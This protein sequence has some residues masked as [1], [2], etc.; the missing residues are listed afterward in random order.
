MLKAEVYGVELYPVGKIH[1][2]SYDQELHRDDLVL[3]MTDFG[4]DVGRVLLGPREMTLE[5]I[6][7]EV[8]PI[9]KKIEG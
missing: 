5:Q 2:F 6:G 8:K 7:G 3:V 1:Y 9:L 4:P